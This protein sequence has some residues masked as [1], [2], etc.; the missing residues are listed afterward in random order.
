MGA[1]KNYKFLI[2]IVYSCEKIQNIHLKCKKKF[3]FKQKCFL[4]LLDILIRIKSDYFFQYIYKSC[5]TRPAIRTPLCSGLKPRPRL[6]STFVIH[7]SA[8]RKR[9]QTQ[10]FENIYAVHFLHHCTIFN[11]DSSLL[12]FIVFPAASVFTSL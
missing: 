2:I 1:C 12:F 3:G 10:N 5:L 6:L 7:G 9:N 8:T 4:F 11:L